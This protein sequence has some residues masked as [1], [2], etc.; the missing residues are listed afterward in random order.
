[1]KTVALYGGSFDPP[2]LGHEAIIKALQELDFI[3][4]I[5]VMPTFLNP[6]KE[7]FAA[8]AALRLK[9]L[10]KIFSDYEKVEVSSFEVDKK[11][12]VPT[13]ESVL[14]LQKDFDRIYLVIGADNLATL[15]EWYRFDELNKLV[16]FIVAS[17]QNIE[18]PQNFLKLDVDVDVSSSALRK[19]IDISKLPKKC[20]REIA[21]YYKEHNAKQN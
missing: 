14:A 5:I 6:F 18:V 9:W 20:A 3:D 12:K 17:R 1:M 16:H 7:K 13:I 11:K 21:H 19:N 10:E 8:P 2:H 15:K 4:K